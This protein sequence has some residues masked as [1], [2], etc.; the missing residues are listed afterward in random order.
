M[1]VDKT[2]IHHFTPEMKEKSKQW[3]SPSETAPKREKTVPSAGKV[4]ATVFGDSQG[5]NLYGLLG[6]M[7][8]DHGAVLC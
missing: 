5:I 6:K 7:K 3:I 4:I 8:D 2:W 1:T